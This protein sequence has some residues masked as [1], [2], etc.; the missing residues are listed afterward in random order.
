MILRYYFVLLK[1]LVTFVDQPFWLPNS[2][3]INEKSDMAAIT[4]FDSFLSYSKTFL[5]LLPRV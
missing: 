2:S 3:Q 1:K 4:L 5:L